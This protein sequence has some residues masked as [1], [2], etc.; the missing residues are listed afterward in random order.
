MEK[1]ILTA[2][3]SSSQVQ[4]KELSL[5]S[6]SLAALKSTD[7]SIDANSASFDHKDAL[8]PLIRSLQTNDKQRYNNAHQL[9]SD[10]VYFSQIGERH[11]RIPAAHQATF[12]WIFDDGTAHGGKWANFGSWCC[13]GSTSLYWVSGKP[14]CGKS[15]LMRYLRDD[16]RTARLLQQ[17]AGDKPPLTASCF[18]WNAGTQIQKS[19]AGLLRS[20]IFEVIQKCPEQA[21]ELA[22]WRWRSYFIGVER[23][24]A[25][26]DEE[27]LLAFKTLMARLANSHCVCLLVDG[28][29][30]FEG[31][32]E[33][34]T[35]IIGVL[36]EASSSAHIKVCVSSRPWP[37]FQD[38]FGQSDMLVLQDL[39]RGDIRQYVQSCLGTDSKFQAL[40]REE[41]ESCKRLCEEIV[42]KAHGVFL[43]V[44]LVVRS[45][46]QGL[47]NAD[48]I[49][50]L[51]RRLQEF[52]DD[53]NTFFKQMLGTI[54][55]F[56]RS[57]AFRMLNLALDVTE[58]LSLMTV[59]YL[60]EENPNFALRSAGRD[61]TVDQLH[62][63]LEKM[64]R[65]VEVRCKGFLEVFQNESPS[66]FDTYRVDFLHRTV[67]D[68]LKTQE[69][70]TLL[71]KD[72]DTRCLENADL[73]V[74][75]ALIAQLKIHVKYPTPTTEN[76]SLADS[77][78]NIQ[79]NCQTHFSNYYW[80]ELVIPLRLLVEL[81]HVANKRYYKWLDPTR[82]ATSGESGCLSQGSLY[83]ND[84]KTAD[85]RDILSWKDP[86]GD[87]RS[88]LDWIL[89]GPDPGNR[90]TVP[91]ISLV[92][93]ALR[94]GSDPGEDVGT[95]TVWIRYLKFLAALA[96]E[97]KWASM[98]AQVLSG[99]T[100]PWM[101]FLEVTK[102]LIQHN[103]SWE[104]D[105]PD[106]D[107]PYAGNTLFDVFELVFGRDDTRLLLQGLKI[108][109]K[110]MANAAATNKAAAKAAKSQSRATKTA[111][112][113]SAVPKGGLRERLRGRL[114]R[115]L[116]RTH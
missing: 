63:K 47:R 113:D 55:P 90:Q 66:I 85:G 35:Q 31:N 77:T 114:I 18:F 26:T 64:Q 102:L 53:L 67:R 49:F 93:L 71:R 34:R 57:Q 115:M 99:E 75:S 17:W 45:L 23:L 3:D 72:E 84:S 109:Q 89:L 37:I 104:V 112:G 96:Y 52:P 5:L 2:I 10:S 83:V 80:S 28:L 98:R 79:A 56:Y 68:F 15:T 33:Q 51:R 62:G 94:G 12:N 54:E 103:P 20:L 116:L 46:R 38:A 95:S 48:E 36:E 21:P 44:F 106:I 74:C 92:R 58:P 32:D 50:D 73:F 24:G 108:E 65:R 13:S 61:M 8:E 105:V 14:G 30:E 87:S 59:S 7:G 69:I 1:R 78:L 4:K 40:E 6:S 60:Q 25:W 76:D 43:W 9:L 42:G 39:T 107:I 22:P 82:I 11:A 41:S 91:D 110:P 19:L 86:S 81:Q 101:P 27:L 111:I 97:N 70:N 16:P 100:L 29:D 88:L